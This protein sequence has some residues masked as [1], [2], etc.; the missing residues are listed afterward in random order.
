MPDTKI[1]T[2]LG[3]LAAAVL[4]AAAYL[5]ALSTPIGNA[6]A[7][8]RLL[9][10]DKGMYSSARQAVVPERERL[11]LSILDAPVTVIRDKRGVPHIY[12]NS[13]RDAIR[14]LGYIVAS[15]RLFQLDF[16]PRVPRGRLAAVLGERAVSSD[17]FLRSTGMAWGIQKN[18]RRIRSERGIE[19]RLIDWYTSGI[20]AYID[21]LSPEELPAEFRLMDYRP[22]KYSIERVLGILQ[23]MVYDLSY[24]SDNPNYSTVRARLGGEAFEK[25]YPE[26]SRL[27]SPIIPPEE[28]VQ[29]IGRQASRVGG[30]PSDMV[31]RARDTVGMV[32]EQPAP[33][34]EDF[35]AKGSNNWGVQGSM[36]ATGAP[37]LAGDMH[38]QLRLPSIWYEVHLVTPEMN[39]YGVTVPGAPLP[40]EG[41]NDRVGWAF[42]NSGADQIDH[43]AVKLDSTGT[44]YRYL[45]EWRDLDLVLDTI[46]V[47]GAD[48]VV[49]TL[50]FSH[51][52]PVRTGMNDPHAIQWTAHKQSTTLAALWEMNHATSREEFE[53]GL[54]RW[55]TPVQNILYADADSNLAIRTTGYV[56][57]RR[58]GHG[59]GLLDGSAKTFDWIGRIP[60]EDMPHAV[61]PSREY[62][63]SANQQPVGPRYGYYLNRNWRDSF[64]SLRIDSLL[65][66]NGPHSVADI[67]SYQSDVKV[68]QRD[69]FMPLID[70]LGGL[71][72]RADTL[73]RMLERWD[74][75]AAVD[76]PEPTILYPFLTT[77]ERLAWDELKGYEKP[78]TTQLWYLM[79]E[80]PGSPW[81]DRSA[82]EARERASDLLR[83][84]LEATVDSLTSR[85]G[86]G[87]DRWRWGDHHRLQ[88]KHITGSSALKPFWRGTYA[89]PGFRNTVS[90][91]RGYTATH[92]A[93]WRMVVDFS[94]QPPQGYGVYPGGQ[95]GNPFGRWYDSAVETYLAFDH[96]RLYNAPSPDSLAPEQRT[97]QLT[98]TP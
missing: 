37:I 77:L 16:L 64:R 23:Y 10:P 7:I 15:D 82:T 80:E 78:E 8:G 97:S 98:L 65:D 88:L 20:N 90:P 56:P 51:W 67:R 44:R 30:R 27:Y 35:P 9:D 60:F 75:R 69:L 70:T 66:S 76:R 72:P 25:L 2:H 13:D 43:Y 39:M 31:P 52:G 81:F 50:R 48:P 29:G 18:A 89:Y 1:S 33:F 14:A 24:R 92:S 5:A 87:A 71:S 79:M 19:Y 63:F 41:F 28:P 95:Q 86:W 57:I 62:L 49:D 54:R 22:E 6:P 42:T 85:Y 91:A 45:N 73:R 32:G 61:N 94:Q 74:G 46:D 12:A 47:A 83:L 3:L 4:L 34:L 93:S 36:S 38:L 17:R 59:K 21:A 96:Y 53:E 55:D 40:I 84:A 58:A 26:D 11:S 68:V